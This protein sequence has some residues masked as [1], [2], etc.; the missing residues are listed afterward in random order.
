MH[1]IRLILGAHIAIVLLTLT[2]TSCKQFNHNNENNSIPLGRSYQQIEHDSLLKV[3]QLFNPNLH[4]TLSE[5]RKLKEFPNTVFI[6]ISDA[7]C[8]SCVE[9]ILQEAQ[10]FLLN[11]KSKSVSIIYS[12]A[13][14]NNF[15]SF[16]KAYPTDVFNFFLLE[17]KDAFQEDFKSAFFFELDNKSQVVSV[18]IPEVSNLTIAEYLE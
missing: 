18:F 5:S 3:V 9:I 16:K 6:Y 10:S 12:T 2:F 7:H 13:Y 4:P 8:Y 15:Y 17:R 14:C 1:T 11:N